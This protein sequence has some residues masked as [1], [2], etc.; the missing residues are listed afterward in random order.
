MTTVYVRVAAAAGTLEAPVL[1]DW[2]THVTGMT[3]MPPPPPPPPAPDPVMAMFSL[4]DDAKSQ[5]FMVADDDDDEATAMAWVNPEIM[6]ESNT[7]AI[8][9]PMF[10]DGANGV[11]VDMG[12]NMPF[13]Y[14]GAEDNW[15]M[16][17]SMVLSDG[18]TFKVQRTMVGAN[19]EM[20][21]TGDVMYITCGPFECM[22]GDTVPELS[23][24]NSGVCNM[25]DP[26]V[27]IQVGKVDNDVIDP[28]SGE[29]ATD[30]VNTNDGIDLGIVTSSSLKMSVKSVFSGVAG[31]TNTSSTNNADSGSNKTLAVK[32]VTGVITVDAD[33]DDTNTAG[34]DESEVCDNTYA[35]EDVSAKLDR[36]AGC[37][38]L[39]GPGAMDRDDAKGP[40]YLS[41]WSLELSP[42]GGDVTWG[43][44]DWKDDPFEDLTC[45]DAD[46]IM[47]SDHVDICE[48]FEAEVDLAT[49]K[50]WKPDV[51]FGAD[52]ETNANQVIMWAASATAGSGE[53]MFKTLWFDDNLNGKIKKD[54]TTAAQA[55]RATA[56]A[57]DGS[58]ETAPTNGLHD[59]YDQNDTAGNITKIWE[60][61]TD[62][63]GDLLDAVG[64]LGKV[65]M[66]SDSDNFQ[67][68]DDE[69]TIAVE[70][71][72]SG[73]S[74]IKG[75]SAATSGCGTA[76]T[77]AAAVTPARYATHPDGKADNYAA[78]TAA[79][80]DFRG[81]SE[82]DGGDD[83]DGSECDADWVHDVSVLFADGTFGCTATRDITITCTWNADGGMAVG[84]NALPT[85]FDGH[86]ADINKAHFLKC[87]AK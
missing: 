55:D 42:E 37:F 57:A 51:V 22:E 63:D 35:E 34:I 38:R 47:V 54:A 74:W 1:S 59:L 17:Q 14:V 41:G 76:G 25:W 50:G 33:E 27:S 31:G 78:G 12:M 58:T 82:D 87:T 32:A 70:A 5:H 66:V 71:C 6:V 8:I 23:I 49:G 13:A 84:R 9:T 69:M 45:G 79:Y 77:P 81:C 15:E 28:D 16:S 83:A 46:P 3:A 11:S 19:Q 67:T 36:P 26:S 7:T 30:G 24:A 65:D 53:K 39:I 64:D 43:S 21:P 80:S 61:L 52:G 29:E 75:T 60:L 68:A 62:S 85:A 56:L 10:V 73:V 48:M 44:V 40:D 4:S 72:A 2:S 86:G 20:E 18:A